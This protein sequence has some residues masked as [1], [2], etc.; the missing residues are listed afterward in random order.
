VLLVLA[1]IETAV[2][3]ETLNAAIV[4]PPTTVALRDASVLATAVGGELVHS[5]SQ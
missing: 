5:L 1:A 2:R 3:L 4:P